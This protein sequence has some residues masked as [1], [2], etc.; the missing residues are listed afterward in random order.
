MSSSFFWNHWI[1][2]YRLV[3]YFLAAM[4]LFSLAFMWYGYFFGTDSVIGWENLQEQKVLE[5]TIHTFRLG[6]FVLDVPAESYVILE[7]L[8]G[9]MPVPN[10]MASYVFLAVMAIGLIVIISCI[11]VLEKLWFYV[12]VAL[13]SVFV[14]ALRL[15]VVGLFGFYHQSVG[16]AAIALYLLPAFFFNQVKPLTP[17]AIRLAFFSAITLVIALALA[18]ASRESYPFYHLVLTSFTGTLLLSAIFMIL[19]AHDIFGAFV[20]ITSQGTTRSIQHLAILSTIYFVNLLL[21]LL[22]EL[23]FIDFDFIFINVF[24]LLTLAGII[25]IWG[26]RERERVYQNI[27]SFYPFGA[28]VF[29]ALGSICFAT[30]ANQLANAND[31]GVVVV[32][33]AILFSQAGYGV[34]FLLY[35]LSN[36]G[37]MLTEDRK[38]Y[39]VLYAPLRMP[40]FTYRLAGFIATI[41]IFI[42]AGWRTYV[43]NSISAFYNQAGD[44]Y[45]LKENPSFADAFYTKAGAHGFANHRSHYTLAMRNASR[46]NFEEAHHQMA[47][48]NLRRPTPYSLTNAG[49][50]YVRENKV[51]ESIPAF[52]KSMTRSGDL[53]AIQNNLAVSYLKLHHFD[54]ALSLLTEA[55]K[56]SLTKNA[57]ETNFFGFA[58]LESIP[59]NV[60]SVYKE[61]GNTSPG[62][63]ANVFAISSVLNKP[64][65]IEVNPLASETLNLHTATLL[66]NYILK[67]A[68]QLDTAFI[69]RAYIVA[70]AP[71]NAAFSEALKASLAY[72]YYHRGNVAR[73]LDILAEQVYLSQSYQGKFN[74]I[75]GLWALEQ[76]NPRLAASYFEYADTYEHKEAR[77]YHAIAMTEAG[78]IPGAIAGW[79]S[80]G[81]HGDIGQKQIALRMKRLLTLNHADA[82]ELGD[83]EKYQ[84][85]RYRLGMQDSTRFDQVVSTF[86]SNNYKAQA[87]LDYSRKF[88][89]RGHL[90]PS[91]RYYQQI[92]GLQL[93]NQTLYEEVRHFELLLLAH[94]RELQ[95]LAT[96][97]NKGIEFGE[98][99]E[100]EKIYYTALLNEA[101]GDTVN[102]KKHYDILA[103]Y[104]PYFE[105]GLLAAFKFF[106]KRNPKGFEPYNILAEAI[107]INGRS[108]PLLRA[109][110][111]E[112]MRVGLDQYAAEAAEKIRALGQG[113]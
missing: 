98:G 99:R 81:V 55:R 17:F 61:F 65:S 104:N 52:R 97:I 42:Y 30:I 6:P 57:A 18:F 108:L 10:V 85:A 26:F 91:I 49:N 2:E 48:A 11:T 34:I 25:G 82:L 54:S 93:S 5:T 107:Q 77:F 45:T 78:D 90:L 94:R 46:F 12:S 8:Q 72:A 109:Y 63:Q 110:H 101:S 105:E 113:D 103:R 67:N 43:Y 95:G 33:H 69:S 88:F 112:A 4:F 31:P 39:K 1:K 9:G 58:A 28:Y 96:Q 37:Q 100:L 60:D 73:A 7:Y 59:I 76:Q 47:S 23:G 106:K 24:L 79:D 32:R 44:F 70:S 3:W 87:L 36:F 89:E 86:E 80:V 92:A 15:E 75:M 16:V 84:Y 53:S 29:L 22:N 40:Y 51:E 111:D 71:P 41:A 35:L 13:F 50:L 102:A 14:F 83:A 68:K 19:V 74:Y 38:V 66:N 27:F 56:H 20:Y 64:L 21:T 62:V